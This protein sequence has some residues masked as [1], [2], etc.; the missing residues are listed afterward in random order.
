MTSCDCCREPVFKHAS[1]RV[2]KKSWRNFPSQGNILKRLVKWSQHP[3]DKE[4]FHFHPSCVKE[5]PELLIGASSVTHAKDEFLQHVS[6]DQSKISSSEKAQKTKPP[7]KLVV[8]RNLEHS[9]QAEKTL[10]E[11]SD[12][13]HLDEA[14]DSDNLFD[15]YFD[16]KSIGLPKVFATYNS[17]KRDFSNA[18]LE[19]LTIDNQSLLGIHLNSAN[20]KHTFWKDVS[21]TDVDLSQAIADYSRFEN[22]N[23]K[24]GNFHNSSFRHV[25]IILSDLTQADFYKADL[26]HSDFYSSKLHRATLTRANFTEAKLDAVDLSSACLRLSR[27]SHASLT[28]ANLEGAT[29][30]EADFNSANFSW[31]NLKYAAA[32]TAN[33][34]NAGLQNTDL[35]GIDLF[36]AQLL[37]TDFL[38]SNLE[39]AKSLKGATYNDLTLFPV[40]FQPEAKGMIKVEM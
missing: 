31:A 16:E 10:G 34:S 1:T 40:G 36:E 37:G 5:N 14:S 25:K 39:T 29:L 8:A 26:R 18:Q 2:T 21:L 3:Q 32:Q 13:N 23:L 11:S 15:A 20:L 33:L 12:K 30:E 27:L 28:E 38:N 19:G 24:G 9:N 7:L 35:E 22:S 6:L 17:G 4:F